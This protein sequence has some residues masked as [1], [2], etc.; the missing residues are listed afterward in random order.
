[1]KVKEIKCKNCMTKSKLTDYVI[2]PYLGCEHSCCYCYA[3]FMKR[4]NNIGDEWGR[5]V[6]VKINCPDL[7]EK[8][9]KKNKTGN[10]WLS[11]VCDCYQPIEKKYRLTRRI[12]DIIAKSAYKDKFT[13]ELLTKSSL[14]KRDFDLIK[15]IGEKVD[16]GMSLGLTDDRIAKIIEPNASL[17][18]ERLETLRQAHEK[19][20]RTYGFI[21]PV[22]PGIAD[23]ED[24]FKK[25]KEAKVDY[26]WVE[27]LNTKK[28]ILDK[29][30]PFIKE[31]LPEKLKDFNKMLDNYEAY[32]RE[33]REEIR[34]LEK[35]YNLRVKEVVVHNK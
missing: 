22:L 21:S 30:I 15:E 33:K 26:V 1:M 32:V 29:L 31:K 27:L 19:G 18:S 23:L 20:I 9:L 12:L 4:F 24:I 6:H 11:S 25:L 2:N 3:D 17:P 5:F 8:E 7:L 35:K 10:I 13:I 28:G 14:I 34:K 16:L